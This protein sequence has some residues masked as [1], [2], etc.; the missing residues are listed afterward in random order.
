MVSEQ[1]GVLGE[2]K[3]VDVKDYPKAAAIGQILKDLNF[4]AEK[5]RI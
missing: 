1:G 4:P 5:K 3:E 2:R